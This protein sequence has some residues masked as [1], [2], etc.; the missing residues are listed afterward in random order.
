ME[1]ILVI[2]TLIEFE[3]SNDNISSISPKEHTT[4]PENMVYTWLNQ[5]L[6]IFLFVSPKEHTTDL[7]NMVYTWFDNYIFYY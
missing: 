4:D 6:L 7:E 2:K 5:F 1:V 3:S